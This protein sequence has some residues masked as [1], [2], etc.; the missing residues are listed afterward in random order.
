M[1][2]HVDDISVSKVNTVF[3]NYTTGTNVL[4]FVLT[5][6]ITV[7]CQRDHGQSYNSCHGKTH[8]DIKQQ[9]NT[10]CHNI[11]KCKNLR[12]CK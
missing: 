2:I 4:V 12:L 3:T 5:F 6:R 9:K 11:A 8:K 7:L 1:D 10:E